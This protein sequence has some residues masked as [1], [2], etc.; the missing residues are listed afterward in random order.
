MNYNTQDC[1]GKLPLLATYYQGY[2]SIYNTSYDFGFVFIDED[3]DEQEEDYEETE[4][5]TLH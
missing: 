1:F 4:T 3:E 5:L 2:D